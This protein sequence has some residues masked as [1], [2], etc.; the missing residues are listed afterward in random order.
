MKTITL[1]SIST[2][3]IAGSMINTAYA[4][5]HHEGVNL[6]DS[7]MT[8]A[9]EAD[10]VEFDSLPSVDQ[11]KEVVTRG[12]TTYISF[13]N[14]KIQIIEQDGQTDVKIKDKSPN[15]DDFTFKEDDQDRDKEANNE[16]GEHKHSGKKFK[17]HWSGFEF[18]LNNYMDQDFS[19][20]RS[21]ESSF[22]DINTG[23]SWNFNWNI[24]QYSLGLGTDHVG[25]V[26]GMGL[27][28]NN[29]HFKDT[30]SI[31]EEN[32]DV[33]PLV[34]SDNIE[35]DNILKNRLQTTYLTVPIILEGQFFNKPRNKRLYA[36]VGVI[37]GI[38]LFS[39]TKVKYVENGVDQK[40]KNKQDFYL[41]P[42]RL[43]VTARLGYRA[44]KL[45]ANYYITPLFIEDKGP[46]KLNPV[47]AGLVVSF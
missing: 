20:S 40:Y 19:F 14:K 2:L 8:E 38:K 35:R 1:I 33:A 26:T 31:H 3:I 6:I 30:T 41:S 13:G 25:L 12:D 47:A 45:Y 16:E 36:G 37:G 10:S 15:E 5:A 18:G 39:N 44:L 17:G 21:D 4:T 7:L 43:G 42:L 46:E 23:K 24:F 9:V 29:Y 11:Q 27:E 28:W 32:S 22:M 34:F